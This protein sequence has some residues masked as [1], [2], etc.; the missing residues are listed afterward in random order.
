MVSLMAL[1]VAAVK[2][3]LM[4]NQQADESEKKKAELTAAQMAV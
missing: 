2:V 3:D 4:E 1:I